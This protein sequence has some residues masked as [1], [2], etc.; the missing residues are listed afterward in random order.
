MA[1]KKRL[2]M[3]SEVDK[4]F[5]ML[6]EYSK[7]L[8]RIHDTALQLEN[9]N[10]ELKQKIVKFSLLLEEYE[11]ALTRQDVYVKRLENMV[12]HLRRDSRGYYV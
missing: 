7:E 6:K 4:M 12:S 9:E 3:S 10:S 2:K 5:T 8:D 1:S 11:S